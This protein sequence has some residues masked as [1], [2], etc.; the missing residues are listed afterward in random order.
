MITVTMPLEKALDNVANIAERG[1]EDDENVIKLL[2]GDSG[3]KVRVERGGVEIP[4]GSISGL[5][6][7]LIGMEVRPASKLDE[8]P[9]QFGEIESPGKF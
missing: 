9:E 7:E 3:L 2:Q 6:V 5:V 8:F 1:L 4:R